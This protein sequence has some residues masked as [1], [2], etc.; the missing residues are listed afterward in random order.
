L[1]IRKSIRDQEQIAPVAS[2]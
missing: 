1:G 2:F